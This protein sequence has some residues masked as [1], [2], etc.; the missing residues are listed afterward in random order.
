MIPNQKGKNAKS[1]FDYASYEKEVMAGLMQGKG[2]LGKDGLLK[3]LIGRFVEAAL[4]AEMEAHLSEEKAS[5]KTG[6]KR[7]GQR[8]KPIRTPSGEV[9][10]TYSRDRLGSF[11]PVTVKKRQHELASGFDEQILE[12][13]AMSN[14]VSDI[15][16]HLE[17]MYGAEMSPARISNVINAT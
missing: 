3:P 16:L 7:N 1:S 5:G 2:L 11:E 13:Y 4:D 15:Q 8:S 6:N 12:L 9:E 17:K 10:I 14:S